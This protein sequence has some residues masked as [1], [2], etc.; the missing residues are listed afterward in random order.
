MLLQ[1]EEERQLELLRFS[2]VLLL[3]AVGEA[4]VSDGETIRDREI[5]CIL[6]NTHLNS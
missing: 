5:K 4:E 1:L 3:L 2:L 6:F